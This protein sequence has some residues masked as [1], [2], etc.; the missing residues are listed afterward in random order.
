[1]NSQQKAAEVIR[2]TEIFKQGC[3]NTTGGSP[4]LCDMCSKDFIERIERVMTG[5]A[6]P[7]RAAA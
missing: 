7:E 6:L 5:E 2:L 4:E 1:M 3:S